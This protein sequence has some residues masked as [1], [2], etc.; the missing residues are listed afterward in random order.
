[1]L[2]K[3]IYVIGISLTRWKEN[4]THLRITPRSY[5]NN[6]KNTLS[7]AFQTSSQPTSNNLRSFA[8]VPVRFS[9]VLGVHWWQ[10][11]QCFVISAESWVG[12]REEVEPGGFGPGPL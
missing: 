4:T 8:L 10:A 5:N 7:F 11:Y 9:K 2:P 6:Q 3:Q 12:E 1:M